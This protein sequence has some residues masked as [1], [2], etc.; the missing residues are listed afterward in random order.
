MIYPLDGVPTI[1][2]HFD[3]I[4]IYLMEVIQI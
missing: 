1:T 3:F 4:F 2:I